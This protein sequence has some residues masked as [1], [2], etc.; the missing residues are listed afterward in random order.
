MVAARSDVRVPVVAH[1][2][3]VVLRG[4]SW[5]D[6]QRVMELRGDKSAPRIAFLEGDLEIMSPSSSHENIKSLI[7]CLVE[8]YCLE[9]DLEFRT[10]GAWTLED[11]AVARGV[12]PDECFVLSADPD[13]RRPDLAI[14]VVWTSGG[15]AKLD[16]YRKLGVR[17]V[18]FWRDG[19]LSVHLLHGESYVT[20]TTSAALP[21]LDLALLA[22]FLDRPTTSAAIKA[23]R[24]A[25]AAPK[26]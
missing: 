13:A 9:H 5:A 1:D 25:L 21:G 4:A 6:Y 26:P 23:Y 2:H 18:W 12:E 16:I 11:K 24:A 17:E 7:G 8:A 3:I 22:S 19:V 14:E 10:L 20:T 15:I